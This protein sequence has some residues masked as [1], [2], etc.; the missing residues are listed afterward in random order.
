MLAKMLA[1]G[2]MIARK[3]PQSVN[4]AALPAARG[5]LLSN[6]GGV[7]FVLDFHTKLLF[8]EITD[9]IWRHHFPRLQL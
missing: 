7:F 1:S 4:L 2:G 9:E 3:H 6:T 5:M 8:E